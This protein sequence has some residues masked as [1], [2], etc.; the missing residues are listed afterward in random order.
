MA[1]GGT[2]FEWIC[3]PASVCRPKE[4]G[5]SA[6]KGEIVLTE[7][8]YQCLR[9]MSPSRLRRS[10]LEAAIHLP[11]HGTSPAHAVVTCDLA[12]AKALLE[13]AE[14]TCKGAVD[15]IKI[16]IKETDA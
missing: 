16:A 15:D 7:D 1:G 12:A 9:T 6:D 8:S 10:R 14:R 3:T 11:G 4:E 5:P 13:V 2:G